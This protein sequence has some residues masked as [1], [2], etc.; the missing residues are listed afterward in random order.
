M[1]SIPLLCS[2]STWH[3][4][5]Y[6]DDP[7]KNFCKIQYQYYAASVFSCILG[8]VF[9][10][11][12]S[13]I[14]HMG[15]SGHTYLA[16]IIIHRGPSLNGY[17][18]TGKPCSQTICARLYNTKCGPTRYAWCKRRSRQVMNI[19]QC[20]WVCE[21]AAR[22]VL[23]WKSCCM[24]CLGLFKVA[25]HSIC[26]ALGLTC[27]ICTLFLP[28][29]HLWG[30][31]FD[32]WSWSLQSNLVADLPTFSQRQ[33]LKG[34]WRWQVGFAKLKSTRKSTL[35]VTR[36]FVRN[37]KNLMIAIKRKNKYCFQQFSSIDGPIFQ[38]IPSSCFWD[39]LEIQHLLHDVFYNL[40]KS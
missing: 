15:L 25:S 10:V 20:T 40:L 32:Y 31:P 27:T 28:L 17:G 13:H 2:T 38:M 22:H 19:V 34:Q 35:R 8:L 39:T 24:C 5:T 21:R 4:G 30:R 16:Q 23:D 1:W 3:T 11:Q 29:V 12:S 9:Y 26:L 14:R 36:W 37:R 6:Q 33:D 18:C 7:C